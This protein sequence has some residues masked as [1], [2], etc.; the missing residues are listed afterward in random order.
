M[1]NG[2]PDDLVMY[3]HELY[4]HRFELFIT[5][6]R[7]AVKGVFN[8]APFPATIW[9]S[10]VDYDGTNIAALHGYFLLGIGIQLDK[11]VVYQIPMSYWTA[12]G[13]VNQTYAQAPD[14]DPAMVV[15]DDITRL[16]LLFPYP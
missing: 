6:C 14:R 7:V 9:R 1:P 5:L 16:R 15:A 2:L 11:Q 8:S 4:E 10:Q 13:F 3:H 12:T